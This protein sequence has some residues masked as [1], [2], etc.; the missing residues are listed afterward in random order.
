MVGG[1][2]GRDRKRITPMPALKIISKLIKIWLFAIVIGA[3]LI[4]LLTKV[5][6]VP[7]KTIIKNPVLG[8]GKIW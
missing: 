6:H 5:F 3:V 4:I 2:R 8:Y 7:T 1:D